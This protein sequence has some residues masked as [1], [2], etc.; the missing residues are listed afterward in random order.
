MV[1]IYLDPYVLYILCCNV[2]NFCSFSSSQFGSWTR[3]KLALSV[4]PRAPA[5]PKKPT[6]GKKKSVES[7]SKMDFEDDVSSVEQENDK[8]TCQTFILK[9]KFPQVY[10]KPVW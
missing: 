3:S 10:L 5:N 2:I 7:T 8:G 1:F 9:E 4:M 6:G